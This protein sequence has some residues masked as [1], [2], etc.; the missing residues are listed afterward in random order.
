MP[1]IERQIARQAGIRLTERDLRILRALA[2]QGAA[3]VTTVR[4]L[5]AIHAGRSGIGDRATRA[6][7]ARWRTLGLVETHRVFGNEPTV[8]VPTVACGALTGLPTPG[9]IPS[10]STLRHTL[11]AAA[12]RPHYTRKG[13]EF[14]AERLI[15]EDGHRPDAIVTHTAS[16]RRGCCEIELTPKANDRLTA[17]LSDTTQRFDRVVYWAP[18][19]IGARVLAVA[20]MALT[21][22]AIGRIRVRSLPLVQP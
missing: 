15:A 8:V 21:A 4:E 5:L 10:L 9:T 16:G 7:V 13:L 17:I 19:E 22:A 12:V 3:Y 20:E 11:L 6:V 2:E 1:K 18:E 14:T